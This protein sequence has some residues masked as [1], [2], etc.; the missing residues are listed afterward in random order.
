MRFKKVYPLFA[1]PCDNHA[2]AS[3]FKYRCHHQLY[4]RIILHQKNGLTI[5][6][7]RLLLKSDLSFGPVWYI[8]D[9]WQVEQERRTFARLALYPDHSMVL[10]DDA[11]DHCQPQSCSLAYLFRSKEWLKQTSLHLLI[12]PN[13]RVL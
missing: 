1:I 13:P 4:V 8:L 6:R 2:I 12:H 10:L 9:Y 3:L 11:V 5:T 7:S